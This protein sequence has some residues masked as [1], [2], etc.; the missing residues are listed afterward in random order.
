[1]NETIRFRIEQ[2]LGQHYSGLVVKVGSAERIEGKGIIARGVQIIDP[3]LEDPYA[4]LLRLDE[5][6]LTCPTDLEELVKGHPIV[7]HVVVRRPQLRMTRLADGSW[8][9]GKLLPLPRPEHGSPEIQI[10]DGRIEVI[11]DRGPMMLR[12]L[13]VLLSAPEGTRPDGVA[14]YRR[15]FRADLTGDRLEKVELEGSVDPEQLLWSLEGDIASLTV[16]Q[17]LCEALPPEV[18]A[19]LGPLRSLRGEA[20]A[21]VAASYDPQA[22]PPLEFELAGH[23]TQ[24]RLDDPRLPHPLTEIQAS[25]TC[26]NRGATI[27]HLSARIGQAVVRH[28]SLECAG[29]DAQSPLAIQGEVLDLALDQ[30]LAELLPESLREHWYKYLPAG[31]INADFNL[32]FDGQRWQPN[33]TVQARNAS[34]THYKFP[35]RLEH[36]NGVVELK[37]ALLTAN[38]VGYAGGQPVRVTAE[39]RDPLG[40]PHGYVEAKGDKV[41]L[42]EKLFSALPEGARHVVRSLEPRGTIDAVGR[43]WSDRPGGPWHKHLWARLNRCSICYEKFPYPISNLRGVLE[44]TDDAWTFQSLEGTND[45]G[46]L[47]GEGSLTPTERGSQLILRLAGKSIPLEK[48]LCDALPVGMQEVWNNFRPQGTVDLEN[49]VISY[50]SGSHKFSV[51]LDARP[52]SENAAITPVRFPFRLDQLEGLLRYRDGHVVLEKFKASHD[53]MRLAT[54]GRA[55]FAPSGSWR[56]QFDDLSVE[57]LRFDRELLQALPPVLQK[58]VAELNPSG[59]VYLRGGEA[60]LVLSRGEGAQD[61]LASQWNVEL[62]LTQNTLDFGLKLENVSGAIKLA[63]G[64]DGDSFHSRGELEIDSLHYKDLQFTQ[65]R[66]PLWIDNERVLFGSWVDR[67]VPGQ[68]QGPADP[69]G[70]QPR[71]MTAQIFGGTLLWD[72]WV[73]LGPTPHYR[74]HGSLYQGDLK[75]VARDLC[76]SRENLRGTI[77]AELD[78]QGAGRSTNSLIGTGKIQLRDADIYEL[79][80][81]IAM[82]KILSIQQPDRSAFSSSDIDFRIEGSRV[83]FDRDA[84]SF[85]GDAISLK[86]RGD[87]DFQGNL[88]LTFHSV[89]GRGDREIPILKDVLGGASQQIMQ[90]HV[91][92]TLQNPETKREPFPGVNHALQKLQADR[93]QQKSGPLGLWPEGKRNPL[94]WGRLPK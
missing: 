81:M 32:R 5:V 93:P 66:G 4:E 36:A 82:L 7:T 8:S 19:K 12:D 50:D 45:T 74:V 92:G 48:E 15:T 62:G 89:V 60:A 53:N 26:N 91:G 71:S 58:T 68:S 55:E 2:E 73:A 3:E 9:T 38:L 31:R 56:F 63:G 61:P 84:I 39:I 79:P 44:M 24:A 30:S 76:P 18:A 87:I 83:C 14:S 11:G 64:H 16:S 20:R 77:R 13:N 42:D 40:G 34:F 54:A 22:E 75:C 72:A 41:Q 51:A 47:T 94:D 10:E 28:L 1:M 35:Y 85:N 33:L 59:L 6:H 21:H 86:G 69:S 27:R 37:G 23:L 65:V 43:V 29:Y 57:R 49:V 52:R 88:S 90:I 78:L 70:R 25:F 17:E 67:P 46:T 80:V